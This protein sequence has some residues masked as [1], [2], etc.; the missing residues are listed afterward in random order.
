L[1][2]THGIKVA[3]CLLLAGA[4][5]PLGRLSPAAE[6]DA[7]AEQL[8]LIIGFVSDAD[9]ETRAMGLQFVREEVRGPAATK[10]LAALLPKLSPQAQVD[11]LGALGDRGDPGAR[12]AILGMLK[13]DREAVR[14]AAL[15]ALGPLGGAA[16]IPLLAGKAAAGS[17]RE[18]KAARKSLAGL[19]GDDVNKAIVSAMDGG[20]PDMR[21]ALL[22][23]LAARNA[24]EALPDVLDSAKDADAGVRLAALGALRLLAGEKETAAVVKAVK[25]AKGAPERRKAELALLAMCSRSRQ[26]CAEA[27][28]DGLADADAA[29]RVVLLRAVA[30][31]GGPKALETIVS[32]LKDDDKAVRD[33]AV[34]LLSSWP[35]AAAAPHLKRIAAQKDNLRHHVLAVR[36]LVRLGCPQKHK[37]ADLEMLGAAM[38]LA[39][40]PQEKRLAL[41]ALGGIA[42]AESLAL[43]A[44]ILDEPAL[45]EEAALAAVKI[46]EKMKDGKKEEVRA[47]M[48]KVV[49]QAKTREIR[50]R[51][52]KV[53]KSL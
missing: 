53:L 29:S 18:K 39:T 46:A 41:G 48:E 35:D 23:V 11:L 45:A 50:D 6:H 9:R 14:A 3:V 1:K 12:P 42:T 43:V 36:G 38:K 34:R 47:A 13:S 31:A 21:V 24:K 33:E 2:R 15:G 26:K 51:A 25:R 16:D 19:R 27:I 44:P 4:V 17:Q 40:R 22:D 20:K 49:K 5:G 8:K 32:R 52:A 30:R 10:A 28:I 7:N 37:P